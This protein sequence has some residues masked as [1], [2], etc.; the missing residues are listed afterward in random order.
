MKITTLVGLSCWCPISIA[1]ILLNLP[2]P[3]L[4]SPPFQTTA[5]HQI[6]GTVTD[7]NGEP[8][9]GVNIVVSGK[10]QGTISDFDGS[11]SIMASSQDTLVYSFVGFK[12]VEFPVSGREVLNVQLEED[13]VALDEVVLNTGYQQ[14]PG[15]RSTGS[16]VHADNELLNQRVSPNI[17]ERL[18]GNVP[19][20][21]FN[22]NTPESA[23]GGLDLNIRGH[24]TLFANDQPLIVVD[25]FPYDGPISNLNPNDI[26][27]IT[28][29]KDAA[30]SSIWGV[31]SGNGVIVITTKKGRLN[32][33]IRIEANIN[34]TIGNKPD[35]YYKPMLGISSNDYIDLEIDNFHDGYYNTTLDNTS[36]FPAVTP[37]VH[38][39]DQIKKGNLDSEAGYRQIDA[40]R[41]NDYR[42]DL[43]KYFYQSSI[44]NQYAVNMRG[45]SANSTYY[46]SLGHDTHRSTAIGNDNA[47]TTI[48]LQV[49][50]SPMERLTI[51]G[52]ANLTY[53]NTKSNDAVQQL[54]SSLFP[55]P[56]YL[57]L[58]NDKTGEAL[59]V[60]RR[61]P[62]Y[63]DTV[64]EGRLLDW[65]YRPY[66]EMRFA[67][68]RQSQIHNRFN[69]RLNYD[70]GNELKLSLQYQY[71]RAGTQNNDH[72]SQDT[73]HT[74][75]LINQFTRLNSEDR[76]PVPLGGILQESHTTLTSHRA[77]GQL[78]YSKGWQAHEVVALL[79]TE[80]NETV[81][82]SNSNTLY[83]YNKEN[84]AFTNVDYTTSFPTIPAGSRVIPNNIGT[85][86]LNDRYLSYF[87]NGSYTYD[88][89][90]TISVSGRIDKSNL[91]G[92]NTNQ[93]AVP[94]FSTGLAWNFSNENFYNVGF[95]PYGKIRLTYGANG[96][97]DKSVTAV[98]TFRSLSRSWFYGTPYASIV[99]PG[100]PDLRW[101]RIKTL[102]IGLDF[103]LKNQIV[104]GSVEYYIKSGED[105]FG[106][107]QIPGS[108]GLDSYY[109]NTS[110][111]RTNGI[112]IHLS[113]I[114]IHKGTFKWTSNLLFSYVKDIVTQY[115]LDISPLSLLVGIRPGVVQPIEGNSL[116]GVYS[117]KWG[118]LTSDTGD[119]QGYVDGK[120]STD[121]NRIRSGTT[122]DDLVYHGSARPTTFGSFRN[123]FSYKRFSVSFNLLFKANYYFRR[124]TIENGVI[125]NN[126]LFIHSDYYDRW[127]QPG[128]KLRTHIPSMQVPPV[129][130]ARQSF[131][132]QSEIFVERGDHI[133]LQD[134][135]LKYDWDISRIT[136]GEVAS[137]QLYS[138]L[139]NIGI[140]WRANNHHI[141][142]D[143]YAGGYPAPFS[144]SFGLNIKF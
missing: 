40:Y 68:N 141:D 78:D 108:T 101:E 130:S 25:N 76:Y 23:D 124:N 110:N 77:R 98:A 70:I 74:R 42:D 48:G 43:K 63:I 15:E 1:F 135:T 88:N 26:E 27:D 139:N 6:T 99:N 14:L 10:G 132:T 41:N 7:R 3:L 90:Y 92:V 142:P 83:G 80:V 55:T 117:Y 19:G 105:L 143:I 47:R 81:T 17:L 28:I 52:T 38:I 29:L 50:L 138:Y 31:K 119:P 60:A 144:L 129:N 127:Q 131:Y 116:F 24:T 72:Y 85:T 36:G 102:N 136:N 86:Q 64:G 89:R 62:A 113:S 16:F 61:N 33:K 56:P 53:S 109:G 11:Y 126:G 104:T 100:N 112:D 44:N 97:I 134:I 94:L 107:S 95:L 69:T 18:E 20:L 39:L 58:V 57:D 37:V 115:H 9:G 59:A 73:Y 121:Y 87:G 51:T 106:L 8:L 111:V 125:Y 2:V 65:H 32:Q 82:K 12:K 123:T 49:E 96:N 22:K 5:Q 66:D 122:V 21:L 93:K 54:N 114:N 137:I 91:F 120:L 84:L 103:G 34:T 4:A 75:D 71:E 67:D 118:G 140:L 30:A 13:V 46:F 133:R 79:G 35:L 45:G 128:D